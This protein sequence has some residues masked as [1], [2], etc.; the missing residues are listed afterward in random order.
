MNDKISLVLSNKQNLNTDTHTHTNH[1]GDWDLPE[2][3]NK[4]SSKHIS[5]IK[6]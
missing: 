3:K 6:V 1:I 2:Y 4:P 5:L